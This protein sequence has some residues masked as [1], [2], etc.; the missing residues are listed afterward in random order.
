MARYISEGEFAEM[1]QRGAFYEGHVVAVGYAYYGYINSEG[2]FDHQTRCNGCSLLVQFL[3]VSQQAYTA[4]L[5]G[6]EGDARRSSTYVAPHWKKEIADWP[7][8][9]K[10]DKNDI[11]KAENDLHPVVAFLNFLD[12][13]RGNGDYLEDSRRFSSGTFLT[14]TSKNGGA[15]PAIHT[16]GA[17]KVK[18][19]DADTLPGLMG[20]ASGRGHFASRNLKYHQSQFLHRSNPAQSRL[21][22]LIETVADV[23]ELAKL[24]Q[25][26]MKIS[27]AVDENRRNN[28]RAGDELFRF[29]TDSALIRERSA[30]EMAGNTNNMETDSIYIKGFREDR[31]VNKNQY[32][33]VRS[34]TWSVSLIS[35]FQLVSPSDTFET[36][37]RRYRVSSVKKKR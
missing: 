10:P 27:A 4:S 32:G 17:I 37:T 31:V 20:L 15:G 33:R 7:K 5:L 16:Q 22:E 28:L 24:I 11:D 34:E 21:A 3:D 25:Q 26:G 14:L 8:S 23:N 18:F 30:Q 36:P 12:K 6:G 19:V 2:N 9:A 13:V 1:R 29:N 35:D